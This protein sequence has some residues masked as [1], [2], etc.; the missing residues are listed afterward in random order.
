MRTPLADDA[1]AKETLP[2]SPMYF[3]LYDS[4]KPLMLQA[5]QSI[6]SFILDSDVTNLTSLAFY[7]I[8]TTPRCTMMTS[9]DRE[10]YKS[11]FKGAGVNIPRT[12]VEAEVVSGYNQPKD[13]FQGTVLQR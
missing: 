2:A 1:K 7:P 5:L 4:I 8:G 6:S 13:F 3:D 9:S 11:S 10:G 12:V